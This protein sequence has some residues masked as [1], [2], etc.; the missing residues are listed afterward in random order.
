MEAVLKPPLPFQFDNNITNVT[1]GNLSKS[2]EEWKK[3]FEIYYQACEFS[4]KDAKVQISI[5][6][7]IIGPRCREVHDTFKTKCTTVD[8]VLEEFDNFFLPKKNLTVERHKFFIR[9]QREFES[10]EQYVFELNKMAAKCEFKDLC[11][12][13]VKDRLICGIHDNSLR[14]RLLRESDLTLKKALDICQLAELSRVQATNINTEVSAHHVN[15][16][17]NKC[18]GNCTGNSAENT[19]SVDWMQQGVRER[20]RRGRGRGRARGRAR[21]RGHGDPAPAAASAAAPS[22]PPPPPARSSRVCYKCGMS[23]NMYQCPAYGAK[24]NKC[25]RY[26]H[27]AKMCQVLYEIDGNSSDQDG[28]AS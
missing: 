20:R 18:C 9:E 5:L 17:N 25:N 11:N 4:K 10:V 1:S 22:P 16:I 14:E 6:L 12:D 3:S 28:E 19:E 26:N 23:H 24:C 27:Y 2:W 21:G 15:E 7:H 8:E 13:L